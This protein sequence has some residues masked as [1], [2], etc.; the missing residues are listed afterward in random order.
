[1]GLE[2]SPDGKRIAFGDYQG[3]LSV[4]GV[5]D[6]KQIEIADDP[7]GSIGD[8]AW[9]PRGGHLAFSMANEA[10]I[11]RLYLWSAADGETRQVT[12]DMFDAY[13]PAWGPKGDYLFYISQRS[14]APQISDLEWNY[15]GNERGGLF[16]LAL[17]RDVKPLLPPQSD[18]VEI[19]D[20]EGDG[21]AKSKK[22]KE[23]E[24]GEEDDEEK[25]S[26]EPPILI[27]YDGLGQRVMRIPIESG[28]YSGLAAVEG[29]LLYFA[30]EPFFYGG[31]GANGS[32]LH[33]FSFEDRKSSELVAGVRGAALSADGKQLLVRKGPAFELYDVK[34]KPG[35]P[36]KVS[37]A[38]LQ[39]DLAPADEW[40]Q[41][42]D[43]TWRLF[44]DYFYVENMHGYDWRAIGERYRAQLDDVAHRSDLN[45]VIAEM[46]AE[47]NAGHTY[48]SGGDFDIPDRPTV[49][50]PGVRFE[51]DAAAGRYRI[52]KI[53]EGHNEE[54]RYRSPLT[55]V[56]V[57]AAVGDYVLAIDGR[58][59]TA[60]DNPYR[61]LQHRTDPVT[62]KVNAKPSLDGAR[63]LSYEPVSSEA[64][65]VYLDWVLGNH[66][67]V[68]EMT[69]GRVGYL[70]VPD[71][72]ANGIA[73]FIKW[74]YP[75]IRKEGLVIDVRSNGGGNVSQMIIERLD[76]TVMGTRFGRISELPATYP[77]TAFHGQLACLVSETSASDGDIFPH[78]F[79]EAGLGPLIGKRT[80]GGVV[81]GSNISLIDGGAVFI[82][83]SATNNA[84]GEYIIEGIGVEPDIQVTNDPASVLA[85]EDP[86]LERGVAEILDAIR[87]DPKRLPER[88]ADPVKLP[89]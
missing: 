81:G 31:G 38:G 7:W 35:D 13:G 20:G 23:K 75:Q 50:L 22:S 16:A 88:P 5:E 53:F 26:D 43:E 74:Y 46:I 33:L 18:E 76:N 19:D 55:A 24:D 54:A 56:G 30:R 3:R 27:D 78:Y 44:R 17:R 45:Y 12:S 71:M 80:W 42:F 58:E 82:P 69:D 32:K 66:A 57:D 47:L 60:A 87:R 48:V 37:V 86:Q 2:W 61:L 21:K 64:A 59:L 4:I 65:L 9:S 52:A 28:N 6:G 62:W 70:H 49:G 8:Y 68:T 89:E 14:Y 73:E 79:R 41:I 11:S 77:Y 25:Q 29:H 72:G 51:L 84:E 10:Q 63:E 34:P 1:M 40:R 85:G 83:R 36:K 15:A 67:R 39:M